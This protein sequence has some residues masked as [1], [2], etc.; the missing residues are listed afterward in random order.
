[1]TLRRVSRLGQTSVEFALASFVFFAILFGVI[2]ISRLVF[3]LNSITTAAREGGR[4][5]IASANVAAAR[6][7]SGNPNLQTACDTAGLSPIASSFARGI[8]SVTVTAATLAED[9]VT[10]AS[11]TDSKNLPAVCSVTVNWAWQ[12][13]TGVFGLIK[14][15]PFSSTSQQRFYNNL[16]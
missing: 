7:Q 2:E 5:G 6:T 3:G 1:V 4:Y 10:P 14:P 16:K 8:G 15:A 13:V 11:N 9:G 12:P